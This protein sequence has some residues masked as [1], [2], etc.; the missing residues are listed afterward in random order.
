MSELALGMLLLIISGIDDAS[1]GLAAGD[2]E[3][4]LSHEGLDRRHWIHVPAGLEP[5]RQAPVVLALHPFA[6]TPRMMMR[7]SGLSTLA[8][9]KGFIVVYP[10][11][12]GPPALRNW[13]EGGMRG[14]RVDDVAYIGRVLDDVESLLPVDR[15][16]VYATGMSNG[17]MMCYRLA[18]ELS[19]RIA[20]IAP[21]AGTMAIPEITATRPVPVLHIH[22]S[23]DRIV[24]FDG[25]G[26]GT[27]RFVNFQSVDAT[28]RAWVRHNGCPETPAESLL[29]DT[30]PDGTQ[31]KS[32]AYRP[33]RDGSEV[34]LEIVENGGHT[35]P[36]G[37][38]LA[39][40]LGPTSQDLDASAQ[41]W[42][43]FQRHPMP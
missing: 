25:P 12:T 13:N 40:F 39:R 17:A 19:T 34:I 38:M 41:I 35:W 14:K 28:I 15:R 8:D 37:P 2:H 20:A 6:S 43:F 3:R 10:S 27:P 5:G 9:A 32:R 21:V 26:K 24:P 33:G 31:V 1:S 4:V 11:G 42:E 16:R 23:A 30:A 7:L 36:G 22:G 29:P 18:S